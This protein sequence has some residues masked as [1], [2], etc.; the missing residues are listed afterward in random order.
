[1]GRV[2]D[3]EQKVTFIEN[4]PE[5][6][7]LESSPKNG[8]TLEQYD[9]VHSRIRQNFQPSQFSGMGTDSKIRE[10]DFHPSQLSGMGTDSKIREQDFHPSQ[11]SGMGTDSRIREYNFQASQ[12]SGMGKDTDL[13]NKNDYSSRI[14]A[15]QN[16]VS[17]ENNFNTN[18]SPQNETSNIPSQ[19]QTQ[20]VQESF[21]HFNMPIGSPSCLDVAEHISK[22][23]ICSKFYNTDKTIYII[24]I[25]TLAI[26][27]I[28][29]LKKV[30]DV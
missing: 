25:I 17:Q 22:C 8:L 6:F 3:S 10:Q 13:N 18:H 2:N 5:L 12:L 26:I 19:K 20:D 16:V 28:L 21:K 30:L 4:L 14:Q 9:R 24:A 11:L 1:M 7:D 15:R 27:C 29:L 23:P